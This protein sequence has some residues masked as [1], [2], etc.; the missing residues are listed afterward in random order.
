MADAT[1]LLKI[2]EA[3]HEND[4]ALPSNSKSIR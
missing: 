1:E 4:E 2:Y 3:I